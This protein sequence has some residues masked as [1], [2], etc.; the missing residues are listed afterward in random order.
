[1]ATTTLA[2]WKTCCLV[3]K[4]PA[5]GQGGEGAARVWDAF[6]CGRL[7]RWPA[8]GLCCPAVPAALCDRPAQGP[9]RARAPTIPSPCQNLAPD[10]LVGEVSHFANVGTDRREE[11][12][13]CLQVGGTLL[14]GSHNLLGLTL[15]CG[16][17]GRGHN[18][19]E[20]CEQA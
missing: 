1:M 16:L 12:S 4:G 11:R 5:Q 20:T 13:E 9:P 19:S 14:L 8:Q 6:A 10:T 17:V 3:A 2:P 15:G 18:A 7:V